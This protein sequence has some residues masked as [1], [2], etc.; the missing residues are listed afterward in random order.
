MTNNDPIL[1]LEIY[2]KNNDKLPEVREL[3]GNLILE[4]P[5]IEQDIIEMGFLFSSGASV[6]GSFDGMLVKSDP[7]HLTNNWSP[8]FTVSD[9]W[10]EENPFKNGKFDIT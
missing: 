1:T 4:I 6:S 3:H 5:L 9:L 7:Y 2:T 10:M 8:V